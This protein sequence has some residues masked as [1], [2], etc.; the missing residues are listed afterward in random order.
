MT[1]QHACLVR[2]LLVLGLLGSWGSVAPADEVQ[3]Y[4][5]VADVS[6]FNVT[7][8]RPRLDDSQMLEVTFTVERVLSSDVSPPVGQRLTMFVPLEEAALREDLASLRVG[9]R[10]YVTLY[11][12]S[13]VTHFRFHQDPEPMPRAP[14][15]LPG[16]GE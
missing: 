10:S 13:P 16:V 9:D 4:G 3:V 1:K 6:T 12:G 15:A 11:T 14:A 7:T 8:D 5:S 2:S